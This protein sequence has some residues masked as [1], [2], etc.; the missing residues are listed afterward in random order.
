M[1][2]MV[3]DEGLAALAFSWASQC[4]WDHGPRQVIKYLGQNL[5][6]TSGRYSAPSLN[7]CKSWHSERRGFSYPDRCSGSVC[8]HYTQM[9]WASSSRV[10][11]AVRKCSN[12]HVFGKTWKEATLLVCNYSVNL[13][14][15][16]RAAEAHGPSLS[17]PAHRQ[18]SAVTGMY[19]QDGTLRFSNSCKERCHKS[20]QQFIFRIFI[21]SSMMVWLLR[22][23]AFVHFDFY[24]A[25]P[26][27]RLSDRTW[28]NEM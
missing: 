25:S 2:L 18:S 10:G 28:G 6:I 3:W 22:A 12:M 20:S 7:L 15:P 5:S 14:G 9:V 16:E 27:A 13:V 21:N 26:A 19:G 23:A 1:E 4:L 11:C 17:W 24:W 8:S